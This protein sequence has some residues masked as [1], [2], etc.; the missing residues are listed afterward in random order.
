MPP[1]DPNS[2]EELED[3]Q[4][5]DVAGGSTVLEERPAPFR[6][7]NQRPIIDDGLKN[8]IG[9]GAPTGS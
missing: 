6:T 1:T 3:E 8:E 7:T 4:L 9:S 2:S 5:D